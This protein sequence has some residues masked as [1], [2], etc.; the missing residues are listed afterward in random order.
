MELEKYMLPFGV[1]MDL[2]EGMISSR[3]HRLVRHLSAMRG[4]YADSAAVESLIA[5]Q[6]DPVHYVTQEYEV[7]EEN[8][9]LRF[10]ISRL[11][12]GVVGDEYFMTKG[13]YH[14]VRETA[15]IYLCLRGE[16]LMLMQTEEG[17]VETQPMTRGKM[18]YVPP[19]WAH[20][21]INTG[22]EPLVSFCIYPAQAGH[23]YGEIVHQGFRR[24]VYH[25]D[26]KVAIL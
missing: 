13:H 10:C 17:Q 14:A 9:H 7:P 1:D 5:A 25:R 8:G 4:Y 15:E 16:G 24:R 6:H 21:S 3:H 2:D 11:E 20:R 12:A 23:D 19:F 18:V 22:A 26:G